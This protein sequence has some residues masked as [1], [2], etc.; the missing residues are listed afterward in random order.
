MPGANE[1]EADGDKCRR[2]FR[3]KLGADAGEQ[4]DVRPSGKSVRRLGI[5]GNNLLANA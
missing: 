4:P 1:F 2:M 3:A 5:K